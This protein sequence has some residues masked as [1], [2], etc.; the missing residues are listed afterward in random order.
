MHLELSPTR[1]AD[2]MAFSRF[3][4]HCNQGL[5]NGRGAVKRRTVIDKSQT[6]AVCVMAVLLAG[7]P[8]NEPRITSSAGAVQTQSRSEPVFYN[9]KTYT[10]DLDHLSGAQFALKVSPMSA[11][12]EKDA[13]AVATSSVGYFACPSGKPGKLTGKPEFSGRT[14]KMTAICS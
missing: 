2:A 14:W 8:Q 5:A 12:Q 11:A 3:M 6:L 1:Y 7:C 10:L 9:G 4:L 13:V